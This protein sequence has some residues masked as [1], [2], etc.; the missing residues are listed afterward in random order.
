[1]FKITNFIDKHRKKCIGIGFKV[2]NAMAINNK[3]IRPRGLSM[4]SQAPSIK[5]V[6]IYSKPV[7]LTDLLKIYNGVLIDFFRGTW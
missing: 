5:T 3:S 6:D 2:S 4:H 1:M 7:D